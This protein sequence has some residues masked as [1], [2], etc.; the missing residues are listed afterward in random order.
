MGEISRYIFPFIPG[1]LYF[2]RIRVN[3]GINKN[4]DIAVFFC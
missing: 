3:D 1:A 4:L 2:G